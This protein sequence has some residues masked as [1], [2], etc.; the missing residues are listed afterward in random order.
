[1]MLIRLAQ[2]FRDR[3]DRSHPDHGRT[4]RTDDRD[5]HDEMQG[6][7]SDAIEAMHAGT[8][9]WHAQIP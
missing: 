2:T 1:M 4:R 3:N 5:R 9:Q 8:L 7:K 6:S